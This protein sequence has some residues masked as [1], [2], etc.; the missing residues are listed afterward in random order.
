MVSKEKRDSVIL[1]AKLKEIATTFGKIQLCVAG[2]LLSALVCAA[3][4]DDPDALT[5]AHDGRTTYR[6][7]V[8]ATASP[9]VKAVAKD[10]QSIFGEMTGAVIP[11]V[12]DNQPMGEREIIIGP[13]KHLDNLAMYIDWDALG[14]QEYVIR[15][16]GPHLALFGGPFGGTRNAV[17]TF[18]DEHLGC[19][20]YSPDFTVIPKRSDLVIGTTHVEKVPVFEARNVNGGRVGKPLWA[21]RMRLS[22][23]HQEAVHWLQEHKSLCDEADAWNKFA[24]DPLL[25]GSYFFAGNPIRRPRHIDEFHTLGLDMLVP[26]SLF[27][28]H[29]DYFGLRSGLYDGKRHPANGICPTSPG[30]FKVV[31]DSA[32]E[33]IRQAP[34]ARIISI[35]MADVYYACGCE[36][37]A[38]AGKKWTYTQ[39]VTAAG[40]PT[41][42]ANNRWTVG[43]VRA[44]GVLLD[45]VNRVADEIH[46]EF[47][48]ILVHTFAYIW[49][50]YPPENWRPADNLIIDFAP[51]SECG[52]HSLS[53]C[54][55]N[56]NLRGYWTQ[57]RLWTKKCPRVWIWR[58]ATHHGSEPGPVLTNQRQYFQELAF[59]GVK[60][61]MVHLC[62]G[63][64][65]W[66]GELRAYVYAKLMWDPE[67]DVDAGMAEY[68]AHAYGAA[69]GPMLQYIRETQDSGNYGPKIARF[70]SVPGYHHP[71]SGVGSHVEADPLS[72]WLDLLAAAEAKAADDPG[73]LARVRFQH[74]CLASYMKSREQDKDNTQGG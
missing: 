71:G 48:D 46:K 19:R 50:D 4:A 56:E 5:L 7:A 20:F 69:A 64:D 26:S 44:A 23:F 72:R 9:Q 67:Y 2:A 54:D 70:A 35:S 45:F 49:T 31:V 27:E 29:P 68:C 3:Y 61:V 65:Q 1:A 36:R 24:R 32:K 42:P 11:M 22:Y 73:S 21:L 34:Y 12:T 39:A 43:N 52:Y 55:Y 40:K 74:D 6:I 62:G 33:W 16:H 37:C 60:G 59:A 58:Y 8:S 63:T 14:E 38:E 25:A 47:P 17:Y 30:V 41:R 66:L 53:Q 13:S 57:L 15:T 18:L 51:L 28:E 10:F